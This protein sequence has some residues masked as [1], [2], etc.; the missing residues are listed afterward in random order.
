VEAAKR[1]ALRTGVADF[2]SGAIMA[3]A[4]SPAV[5]ESV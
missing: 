4:N 1:D 3:A 2:A 5:K